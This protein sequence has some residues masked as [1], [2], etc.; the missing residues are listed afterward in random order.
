VCDRRGRRGRCDYPVTA[1]TAVISATIVPLHHAAAPRP[2]K[3][4]PEARLPG[5]VRAPGTWGPDSVTRMGSV[6]G[7]G[8]RVIQVV[9]RGRGLGGMLMTRGRCRDSDNV[10]WLRAVTRL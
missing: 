9:V 1:V 6:A 8:R 4:N 5:P 2:D 10:R 3:P 7:R